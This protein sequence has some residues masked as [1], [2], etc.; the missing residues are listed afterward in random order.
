MFKNT[1]MASLLKDRKSTD[2]LDGFMEHLKEHTAIELEASKLS[3]QFKVCPCCNALNTVQTKKCFVCSW[4]GAFDNETVHVTN[5]LVSL[6]NKC[7]ELLEAMLP[8]STTPLSR[9]KKW[10]SN[11]KLRFKKGRRVDLL[12]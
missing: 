3:K 7:P 11:V 6:M 12:A 2:D 4:H 5:S 9:M 10:F 8:E 1:R